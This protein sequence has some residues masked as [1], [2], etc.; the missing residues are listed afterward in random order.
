MGQPAKRKGVLGIRNRTE[1]WKT[2][3][4]FAPLF[5]EAAIG[6]AQRLDENIDTGMQDVRIELFW[7]GMRD[8]V[9]GKCQGKQTK[10]DVEAWKRK[11]QT[12]YT[13][14]FGELRQHVQAF[15]DFHLLENHNYSGTAPDP[16]Y[17]NLVNTEIDIVLDTPRVLFIGEAKYEMDLAAN[18]NL[19][20]V[21][22]F[23]RQYVMASILVN[24]A[25]TGKE[26]R[27][28]VVGV[29]KNKRQV[30]FAIDRG[31]MKAGN[32]LKWSDIEKLAKGPSG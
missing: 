1:N 5:G 11:I 15:G 12:S 4:A 21:H 18:R 3:R 24:L 29:N 6:L 25:G 13:Q 28:F 10:H 30:Q 19:V 20:L 7:A 14:R 31:W 22:Q 17:N 9:F 8:F 26:V 23:I 2:A 32:V 16:L 27:M